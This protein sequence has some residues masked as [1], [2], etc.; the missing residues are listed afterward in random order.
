MKRYL[1]NWFFPH[2]RQIP[3]L[4]HPESQI[5]HPRDAI[6]MSH[7]V[8]RTTPPTS[9]APSRKYCAS[10]DP[11]NVCIREETQSVPISR[12]HP[13]KKIAK[14]IL[15]RLGLRTLSM[16]IESLGFDFFTGVQ[17]WDTNACFRRG[18]R[19]LTWI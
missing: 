16:R 19:V 7:P 18:R 11:K 3:F 17:L 9:R 6:P 1:S 2:L 4:P 14:P 13:V 15:V 12:N 5:G 8:S 10:I